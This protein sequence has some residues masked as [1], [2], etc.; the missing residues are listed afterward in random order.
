MLLFDFDDIL[1]PVSITDI[2]TPPLRKIRFTWKM[3][4]VLKRMKNE[5]SDICDFIFRVMVDFV[6]KI[7]RK[8]TNFENKDDHISKTKN[9]N[10]IF[11]SFQH[12]QNL[13][14]KYDHPWIFL[15]EN[16]LFFEASD[17]GSQS[18][19]KSVN[20]CWIKNRPYFQN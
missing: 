9:R 10:L 12:I 4:N 11:Y 13:S 7:N 19:G 3:P 20:H 5:F 1:G 15:F 8:W 6:L 14:C 2:Q 18:H 16:I 17:S